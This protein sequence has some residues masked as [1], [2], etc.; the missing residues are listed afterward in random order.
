[1]L[2]FQKENGVWTLPGK[3]PTRSGE[4]SNSSAC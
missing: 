3:W 1:V 4:V 2:V